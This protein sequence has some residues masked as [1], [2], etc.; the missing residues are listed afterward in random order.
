M[1]Y[2]SA[3]FMSS[4]WRSY[5]LKKRVIAKAGKTKVCNRYLRELQKCRN[6]VLQFRWIG[7]LV[8]KIDNADASSTNLKFNRDGTS[9]CIDCG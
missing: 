2:W 8:S 9:S 3:R 6:Y 5:G 7:Q 1:I 4:P